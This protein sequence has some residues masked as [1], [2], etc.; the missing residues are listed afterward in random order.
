VVPVP[1]GAAMSGQKSGEDGDHG[2]VTPT[3]LW[4]GYAAA[5]QHG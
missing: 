1:G 3:D 5:L 4:S 2:P